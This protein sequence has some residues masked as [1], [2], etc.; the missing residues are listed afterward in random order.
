MELTAII[1]GLEALSRPC[2]VEVYSDSRYAVDAVNKGWLEN[3][4]SNGWRKAARKGQG[5]PV[6]NQDL[7]EQLLAQLD[8]HQVRFNWVRGHSGHAENE[9]ADRLAVSRIPL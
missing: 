8:R 2:E 9:R 1:K 4:Q 3:W 5:K 7:W 6:L